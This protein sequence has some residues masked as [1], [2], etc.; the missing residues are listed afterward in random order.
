MEI[1]GKI[2][3]YCPL[4]DAKGTPGV[5]VAVNPQGYYQVEVTIKGR[6]HTVFAPVGGAAVVFAEPEPER[7]PEMELER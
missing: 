4:L 2:S 7:D 5:L 1:P 3:L 6:R